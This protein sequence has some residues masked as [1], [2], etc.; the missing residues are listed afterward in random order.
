MP[1]IHYRNRNRWVFRYFFDV[2]VRSAEEGDRLVVDGRQCYRGQPSGREDHQRTGLQRDRSNERCVLL[3]FTTVAW[4]DLDALNTTPRRNTI[5]WLQ[6][7]VC[8]VPRRLCT[9]LTRI[10]LL[11]RRLID[12]SAFRESRTSMAVSLTKLYFAMKKTVKQKTLKLLRRQQSTA[13]RRSVCRYRFRPYFWIM[14]SVTLTCESK[15][16]K[17]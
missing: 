10:T 4:V 7:S 5:T 11:V 13:N 17:T 2:S 12:I 16:S 14:F 3:D 9:A 15:T 6:A 8:A 1:V